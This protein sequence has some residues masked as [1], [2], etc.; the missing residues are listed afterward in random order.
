MMVE[1]N[2]FE[3]IFISHFDRS[4]SSFEVDAHLCCETSD[5]TGGRLYFKISIS[6]KIS[7]A[8]WENS[9]YLLW[10]KKELYINEVT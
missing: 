8:S 9:G 2:V 10:M 1:G 7:S 6:I 4:N 3:I 5:K